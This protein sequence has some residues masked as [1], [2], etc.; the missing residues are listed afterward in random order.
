M[1]NVSMIYLLCIFLGA[2]SVANA[3]SVSK[4]FRADWLQGVRAVNLTIN[5][6]RVTGTFSVA[7]G[8]D[9]T[10]PDATYKFS[11]TLKGNTLTVAFDGNRLPDVSPSEMKSLIW[12]LA[13]SGEKEV[14]RI[15]FRG[16]NYETNKYEDSL[17]DFAACDDTGYAALSKTA[18]T[19]RFAKGKNS[20]SINL[21]ARNE[22]Q[23]MKSPATFLINVGKSQTLEV[24]ADGCTIEVYLPVK[25]LYEYVE[26]QNEA[27]TEKTFASS[28]I[29]RMMIEALP[30]AGTYL[31]VLRKAAE[32]MLPETVTFKVTR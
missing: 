26:W 22:F 5:G 11:G 29:D 15:K 1:K 30:Q 9:H 21:A 2:G 6:G 27:K 32:N 13:K 4:C 31:V 14:L 24:R 12:T 17:A 18:Q 20:A 28:Q 8:D 7:S 10:R 19:V 3:Q 23:A 16:K 25:K